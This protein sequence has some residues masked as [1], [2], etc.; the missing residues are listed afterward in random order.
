MVPLF[1][2]LLSIAGYVVT[3]R[4][5]DSD[6][7][8][9]AHRQ[10]DID[11]QQIRGLLERAA[12]FEVGLA[13]ALKG[14][15][16]PDGRRFAT[17]EGSAA[18]AVEL[19]GA[20]WVE[21]VTAPERRAYERRIRT[22]ITRL[23]SW[24]PAAPAATYLPATFVTGL[25]SFHPGADMSGLPALAATLRNPTSI[26]AG[27]ATA[28]QKV[29]G[30]RGFFVVQGAQ[31]GRGPGSRGFLVVFV[32]AAW[33]NLSLGEDPARTAI[34]LDG[35]RLTGTLRTTPAATE[36]FDALTRDW[37]VDV[38]QQPATEMQKTLPGLAAA[39]PPATAL[40]AFLV[41]RGMLRRRRAEREVDDIFDLSLDLL[42]IIGVDGYLKRVNPAFE[43]TLGYEAHELLSSPL[44]DFVHPDDREE[45]E[46]AIARLETGQRV[47]AL[48]E[49][50][51]SWRRHGSLAGMERATDGRAGPHLRSGAR[52]HG[53]PNAR[54][55]TGRVAP[56]DRR[57]RR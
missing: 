11:A 6:R 29:R 9:A 19:T 25:P 4:V 31:F 13:S 16:V 48:R 54:R 1:V 10:A 32:P 56:P 36:Q 52:R 21:H 49:P 15:R 33:L 40:V 39:W 43:R 20:M 27:T 55:R 57:H 51:R 34:S 37:R 2:V 35:R 8:S 28:I 5:V 23:P 30:R 7:R 18:T 53:D 47:G 44:L 24:Q 14:E 46:K 17:L 22:Q 50:L 38:A 12:T 45:V 26:F 41:G 42:C 3:T